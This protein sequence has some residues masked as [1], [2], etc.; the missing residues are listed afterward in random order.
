MITIKNNLLI[1]GAITC[2]SIIAPAWAMECKQAALLGRLDDLHKALLAGDPVNGAVPNNDRLN[3]GRTALHLAS[4]KGNTDCVNM[5]IETKGANV[6]ATDATG[7]TPLHE[8][9][10]NG[11]VACILSL[12][13]ADAD[14]NAR[15]TEHGGLTPLHLAVDQGHEPAVTILVALGANPT[16]KVED[17]TALDLASKDQKNAMRQAIRR[18]LEMRKT[19]LSQT[20]QAQCKTEKK[21]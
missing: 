3:S 12:A 11:S 17:C 15:E 18:G 2:F 6:N 5:L 4:A 1:A 9:A 7:C 21:A 20:Q 14:I 8:A 16:L 19:L 13:D 10:Y